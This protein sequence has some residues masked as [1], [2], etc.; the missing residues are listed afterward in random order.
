MIDA[1]VA[2][3]NEADTSPETLVVGRTFLSADQPQGR[4]RWELEYCFCLT[5]EII[6]GGFSEQ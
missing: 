2:G 4:W 1:P 5:Q 3:V 6:D